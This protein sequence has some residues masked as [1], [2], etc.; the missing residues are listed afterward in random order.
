MGIGPMMQMILTCA[1]YSQS[2]EIGNLS[3]SRASLAGRAFDA[4]QLHHADLDNTMLGKRVHCMNPRCFRSRVSPQRH[5]LM[6]YASNRDHHSTERGAFSLWLC[7]PQDS[8]LSEKLANLIERLGDRF[9]A[10]PFRPHVTLL[11][12]AP[13]GTRE[14]RRKHVVQQRNWQG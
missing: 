11:G 13:S 10:P 1:I 5:Q 2:H 6:S 9:G 4:R 8:E 7:P 3:A 14:D 12:N